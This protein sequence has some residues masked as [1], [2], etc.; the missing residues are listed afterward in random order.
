MTG[1]NSPSQPAYHPN[2]QQSPTTKTPSSKK[3]INVPIYLA[4]TLEN[5]N[6]NR[7]VFVEMEYDKRRERGGG[8]GGEYIVKGSYVRK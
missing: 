8:E 2:E 3:A 6:M 7:A 4:K 5:E 1:L